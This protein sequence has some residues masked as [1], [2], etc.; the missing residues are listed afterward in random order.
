MSD[1]KKYE[2]QIAFY[3]YEVLKKYS[4]EAHPMKYEEIMGKLMEDYGI[5]CRRQTVGENIET[6][7]KKFNIDIFSQR[8]VGTYLVERRFEV[9]EAEYLVDSIFSNREISTKYARDLAE[10]I[11][12]DFSIYQKKRFDFIAKPELSSRNDNSAFFI[13]IEELG[14]A[15]KKKKK[16]TFDYITYSFEGQKA[17]EKTA[18]PYYLVNNNGKYYLI[19]SS[20]NAKDQ[21]LYFKNYRVDRIV[22]VKLTNKRI[23]PINKTEEYLGKKFNINEYVNENIYMFGGETVKARLKLTRESY[24]TYIYDWFGKD[25]SKDK[26]PEGVFVTVNANEQALI[27]WLL[28]YSAAAQLIYPKSTIEK[29]KEELKRLN[30][31]YLQN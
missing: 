24:L 8:G 10:K 7:Q 15:I 23:D 17:S 14:A 4:D 31:Y 19:A 9:G 16:V 1:L 28:Q 21:K 13:T 27:Y 29:V 30:G 3:I 20:Y 11:Y 26:T 18:S 22:N 5:S 25:I 6:L 2:K 12:S